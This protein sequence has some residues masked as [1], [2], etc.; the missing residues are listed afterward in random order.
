MY[1]GKQTSNSKI[2]FELLKFWG[3]Q[4]KWK[5]SLFHNEKDDPT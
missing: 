1:N 5:I 4:Q 2:S 3:G